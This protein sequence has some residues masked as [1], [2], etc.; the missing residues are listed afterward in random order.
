MRAVKHA[1]ALWM[2]LMMLFMVM[3]SS[4]EEATASDL[5]ED[6]TPPPGQY[7]TLAEMGDKRIGIPNG[8]SFD[9]MVNRMFPNAR[10]PVFNSQS[11]L[12]QALTT[13]KIDAFPSDEP[14]IRYIMGQRNDVTYIPEY[15]EPFELAYCFPRTGE[16]AKLCGEFSEFIDCMRED[17]RLAATQ[18]KWF[19]TDESAK[20]MPDWR[21]LPAINGTVVLATD[22]DYVPFE[23]V[24]DNEVVGY[25]IDIAAQ[26][27]AEYGYALRIEV[28]NFDAVVPA[29][30]TGKCNVGGSA[31]TI[32]PERAENVLFSSPNYTGGVVLVVKAVE[33]GGGTSIAESFERTFIREGRWK[34]FGEGVLVTLLITLLTILLGTVLGFGVFMV[35]RNGSRIAN[36]VTRC[37]STLIQGMPMVVLLMILYYVVFRS[38]N[39]SGII[40]A[41][42]GMTLSFGSAVFGMLKMGVGA[43]DPGQYEAAYALG[44]T[45][46]QTFFRVILPQAIPHVLPAYQ[47]EIVSLIK[48]TAIVGYIG[49]LDLTKMGDIVRSRTFEAFFPLIAVT[50]IYFALE[51]IFIFAV[52]R[53]GKA[54]DPKKRK[55][56]KILKGVKTDD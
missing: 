26:F 53:I 29:V 50:V 5:G 8:T 27:C 7:A 47:G 45:N 22:G 18:E 6:Y 14:V 1:A 15:L 24:R 30:Q 46:R 43:V 54:M 3:A 48:A 32:T 41:V 2:S 39:I 12:L 4:A 51:A 56:G 19:G 37:C 42:I 21:S 17:G 16:G 36:G 34:L 23:Y 28:M 55:K 49:V 38:V 33:S 25:D 40:V 9:L 11:D 35:C 20:T 44:H 13:D 52:S 31:L 10:K